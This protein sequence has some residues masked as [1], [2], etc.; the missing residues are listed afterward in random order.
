MIVRAMQAG[1]QRDTVA[2][3]LALADKRITGRRVAD[4]TVDG[5]PMP[6][7][8][9]DLSAAGRVTLV[10]DPKSGLLVHQRFGGD[11]E[12]LTDERF[13]EYRPVQGLQVAHRATVRRE[14]APP[15]DRIVRTFEINVPID[16]TFFKKP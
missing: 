1:V 14:N 11:G 15:F 16:P 7:L 10:F 9:V 3:L 13:S 4:V 2:L 8:E 5:A 6:A 12:P